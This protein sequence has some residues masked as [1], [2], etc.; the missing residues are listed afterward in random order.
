M[1]KTKRSS[2]ILFRSKKVNEEGLTSQILTSTPKHPFEPL[3]TTLFIY[4]IISFE[5]EDFRFSLILHYPNPV[6]VTP[7]SRT[8]LAC[9][10]KLS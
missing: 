8:P 2:K 5:A 10:S 6:T 7:K 9:S 3:A 1:T 4:C